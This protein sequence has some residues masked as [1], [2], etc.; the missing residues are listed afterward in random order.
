MSV[1]LRF[2]SSREGE[3]DVAIHRGTLPCGCTLLTIYSHHSD[4]DSD[5]LAQVVEGLGS[6]ER[7]AHSG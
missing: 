5:V 6:I 4:T 7:G 1:H 2:E 3:Q